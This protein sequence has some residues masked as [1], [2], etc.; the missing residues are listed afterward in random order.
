MAK[1]ELHKWEVEQLSKG[2][3]YTF[4]LLLRELYTN[5]C[6]ENEFTMRKV[7][8]SYKAY[9]D[10]SDGIFTFYADN[11]D[12]YFFDGNMNLTGVKEY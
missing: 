11:G 1:R 5:L 6:D 12:K 9:C 3:T 8:G 4:A 7:Q 10:F 2:N